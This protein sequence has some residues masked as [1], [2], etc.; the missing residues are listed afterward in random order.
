MKKESIKHLKSEILEKYFVRTD[1]V[2]EN[3]CSADV[4]IHLHGTGSRRKQTV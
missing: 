1:N 2:I 3:V 4:S